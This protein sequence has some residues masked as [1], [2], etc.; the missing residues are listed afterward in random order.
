M[1]INLLQKKNKLMFFQRTKARQ[2]HSSYGFSKYK[3][4]FKTKLHVLASKN[5]FY[6]GLCYKI[7]LLTDL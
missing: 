7:W 2:S 3:S 5:N 4:N 6:T 1:S